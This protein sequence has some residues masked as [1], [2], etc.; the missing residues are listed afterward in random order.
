[1]QYW[2]KLRTLISRKISIAKIQMNLINRSGL[3]DRE[4]YLTSNPDVADNGCDPLWHFVCYGSGELRKPHPAFDTEYYSKHYKFSKRYGQVALVHYIWYGYCKGYRTTM[5]GTR[6]IPDIVAVRLVKRIMELLALIKADVVT[7]KGEISMV[8][9]PEQVLQT[10]SLV[11]FSAELEKKA[12]N[13]A[14]Y[15]TD[16]SIL[17]AFVVEDKIDEVKICSAYQFVHNTDLH[18]IKILR[19]NCMLRAAA[20]FSVSSEIW[21]DDHAFTNFVLRYVAAGSVVIISSREHAVCNGNIPMQYLIERELLSLELYDKSLAQ[22]KAGLETLRLCNLADVGEDLL[23]QIIK[24]SNNRLSK[25]RIMISVYNFVF[26]GG[27]IMPI[28]L[29][30]ELQSM[31]YPVLVHVL[32]TEK[33]IKVREMLRFDIPVVM[34]NN[35]SDLAAYINMYG[36]DLINTHH[37]SMQTLCARMMKEHKTKIRHIA[38]THGAYNSLDEKALAYSLNQQLAGC[39]AAWT[40]VGD[41]NIVP[42]QSQ[43]LYD[44]SCFFKVPNGIELPTIRQLNRADYGI[45]DTAFVFCLISRALFQK[46]WLEAVDA[47]K[48]A[49]K[50]S[51][52]DLR[53]LLIGSGEA[54]EHLLAQPDL[55]S[56]IHLMG[57]Q[58]YPCDW[59][60]IADAGLLPTYYQAESAPLTLIECLYCGKP[61]LATDVGDIRQMLTCNDKMAGATI[62]LE[63]GAVNILVLAEQMIEF[64]TDKGKYQEMCQLAKAKSIEFSM[65]AAAKKYLEV[66]DLDIIEADNPMCALNNSYR[67]TLNLLDRSSTG[68]NCPHVTVVVPNYN[69]AKYLQ[70]RLDSIYNQ[71]YRNFD[72][73]L[74]DDCSTDDSRNILERYAA[75][76]PHKT[77]LI[78]NRFNSGG[79]FHQWKKGILNARSDLCWIAE[80][81]DWCD[82]TFLEKLVP[83]FL[84]NNVQLAYA[85]YVFSNACGEANIGAF[86]EY[87]STFTDKNNWNNNFVK[88]SKLFVEE[89]LGIGNAIPNASGVLFRKLESMPL[90]DDQNWL[91]MRICGD[92]VFYL[93]IAYGGKIAYSRE[94]NSY[95]TLAIGSAGQSTYK[96]AVY[97]QEHEQVAHTVAKLYKVSETV[98]RKS[99]IRVKEFSKEQKVD[100]YF[101][102]WY[103]SEAVIKTLKESKGLT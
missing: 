8:Y 61:F 60:N 6:P 58:Q 5:L 80:T 46:G 43:N 16:E 68:D 17:A 74:L 59:Y 39:V 82:V 71:T 30:N 51:G 70:R 57:Y 52:L 14:R 19:N 37:Q 91:N 89:A 53:L 102:Q 49:R 28:R 35:T 88:D 29:A 13:W 18:N 84:D 47:I 93:H 75:Q 4:Y 54:Y 26:G 40:Y 10:D 7:Y 44:K 78:V 95:F 34:I 100:Q 23:M 9:Q 66:Y 56:Y 69:H 42:F 63:A 73:L 32:G 12:L 24:L 64:A 94:V 20:G 33:D 1:M 55:P 79:V 25:R 48:Q 85:H 11:F 38:T 87:L 99:I 21:L 27:E 62:S 36:M 101:S 50:T 31:G 77:K 45:P 92:W 96:Q 22:V 103:D 65:N 41:K 67:Y 2:Q 76:Y 72:V 98:I 97:Y 81:D 86:E 3:F 15:F 90:L 83:M